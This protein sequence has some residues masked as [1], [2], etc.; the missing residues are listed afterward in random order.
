[1]LIENLIQKIILCIVS[2]A[3]ED[4]ARKGVAYETE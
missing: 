1:M 3:G 2:A 4:S